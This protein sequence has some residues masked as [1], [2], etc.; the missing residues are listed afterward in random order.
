MA[1]M[2]G[3]V[4]PAQVV[5]VVQAPEL[6]PSLLD[7]LA[8]HV[9]HVAVGPLV[10]VAHGGR[11]RQQARAALAEPADVHEPAD[12]RRVPRTMVTRHPRSHVSPFR[13]GGTAAPRATGDPTLPRYASRPCPRPT[14]GPFVAGSPRPATGRAS[15]GR[16]PAYPRPLAYPRPGKRDRERTPP[17]RRSGRCRHPQTTGRGSTPLRT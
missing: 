17:T 5:I 14:S 1:G 11:E 8:Q 3:L 15:G 4:V 13:P 12:R 16:W 2:G 7:V 10:M 9:R 6:D